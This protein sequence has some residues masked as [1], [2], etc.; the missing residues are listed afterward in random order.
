MSAMNNASSRSL[1]ASDFQLEVL[2]NFVRSNDFV[3]D[4]PIDPAILEATHPPRGNESQPANFEPA[5]ETVAAPAGDVG[6]LVAVA[7]NPSRPA[8]PPSTG[9]SPSRAPRPPSA[10][11]DDL[12]RQYAENEHRPLASVLDDLRKHLASQE[13]AEVEKIKPLFGMLWYVVSAYS[14]VDRG[15]TVGGTDRL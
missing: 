11:S 13:P 2:E 3:M 15:E 10:K 5:R 7:P 8:V 4:P 9:T 6:R 1:V 14:N 12:K